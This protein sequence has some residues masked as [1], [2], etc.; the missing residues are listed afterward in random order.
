MF[1]KFI[2][3]YTVHATIALIQMENGDG[4]TIFSERSF[5]GKIA[6]DPQSGDEIIKEDAIGCRKSPSVIMFL[7]PNGEFGVRIMARS[8]LSTAS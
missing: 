6:K 7:P 1:Y 4:N 2:S 8:N 5:R 3:R